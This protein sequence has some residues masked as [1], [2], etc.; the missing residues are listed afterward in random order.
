M[1]SLFAREFQASDTRVARR[2]SGAISIGTQ[3]GLSVA[4]VWIST[5]VTTPKIADAPL[6]APRLVSP[7]FLPETVVVER[8]APKSPIVKAVEEVK[9]PEPAPDLPTPIAVR[10]FENKVLPTPTANEVRPVVVASKPEPPA[11][12]RP[13]PVPTLGAF[14]TAASVER[15]AEPEK[16][17][18]AAGFDTNVAPVQRSNSGQTAIGA[19]DVAPSAQPTQP[20][21]VLRESGFGAT[22]SKERPKTEDRAVTQKAGFS[23]AKVVEPTRRSESIVRTPTVVPVQVLSKPTPLYTDEARR[24]KVEGEVILEVEFCATGAVRVVRVVRGLGHGLDESAITA[25]RQIQFKPA[26]SE[27][28]AVDYR[29]TVQIVFRLA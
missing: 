11:A 3:L 17:I 5:V 14:P 22:D 20:T 7:I 19:F 10:E 8:P 27:G 26:T 6:I 15:R 25:A 12:P 24:L 18:A 13:A 21:G 9:Q 28:R 2:V 29:T 16:R 23:D 4:I 1:P